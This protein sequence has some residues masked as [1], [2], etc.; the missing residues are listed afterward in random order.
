MLPTSNITTLGG[1]ALKDD[2]ANV[3]LTIFRLVGFYEQG[4]LD[5]RLNK[6]SRLFLDEMGIS[7][8]R[9]VREALMVL[10]KSQYFRGPSAVHH[11]EGNPNLRVY[12]FLVA[13]YKEQLYVKFY[14]STQ[15]AE[16][17]SLHPSEKSPDQT[18][19]KFK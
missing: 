8:K 13:L 12:E 15:G 18:F 6:K 7:Y 16:L 1:E 3:E 10:S 9:M 4:K 5:V 14:V 2:K 11:Q 19:T 17:R